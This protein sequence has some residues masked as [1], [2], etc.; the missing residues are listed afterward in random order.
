MF[1]QSVLALL[2]AFSRHQ[3]HGSAN[4][5][6]SMAFCVLLSLFFAT[7]IRDP[8]GDARRGRCLIKALQLDDLR[9]SRARNVHDATER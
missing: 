6:F 4:F 5:T 3:P 9:T 1:L 7:A 2:S 8:T